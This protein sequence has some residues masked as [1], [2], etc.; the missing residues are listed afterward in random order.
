MRGLSGPLQGSSVSGD[1]QARLS[2]VSEA[3]LHLHTG[4]MSMNIHSSACIYLFI[5]LRHPVRIVDVCTYIHI[6]PETI[7]NW[8]VG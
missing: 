1:T 2:R 5:F 6:K 7:T 3:C 8:E 4:I